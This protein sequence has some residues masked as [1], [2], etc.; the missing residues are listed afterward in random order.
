MQP[1]DERILRK[2]L[3]EISFLERLLD[4]L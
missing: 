1:A 3:E 2:A 4:F